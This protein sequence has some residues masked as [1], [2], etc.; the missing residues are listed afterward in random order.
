MSTRQQDPPRPAPPA[1]LEIVE[2]TVPASLDAP[3]SWPVHATVAVSQAVELDV[4]GNVDNALD[5]E[6]VIAGLAE[7]THRRIRRWVATLDGEPVGRGFALLPLTSNTHRASVQVSVV[8]SARRRGVGEALWRTVERVTREEG[9]T[10]L[11]GDSPH[12]PEPP[13]GPGAL[14]PTTGAGRAPADDAGVRFALRHGFTLEQVARHSVLDLPV[15]PEELAALVAEAT[16]AA[17]P[18]YRVHVWTDE[19]PDERLDGIAVLE[20][21]MSTDAPVGGLD[22]REDPW[23]ADRVRAAF[24]QIHEREARYAVCA[25]E[26]V[27]G[28]TLAG[29]TVVTLPEKRPTVV[30]QE[31]TLVLRE[32]RGHRLGMLAKATMLGELGRSFPAAERVHTWN[33]QENDAMLAIN[34]A[35][36]FRPAGIDAEWQRVG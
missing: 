6:G 35:L 19:I 25:V 29:F 11:S 28:G 26:H 23:D 30:F 10:V 18:D 17:G 21:R 7:S 9:R 36:G 15:D 3:D 14:E 33:A 24:A 22:R 20:T 8:P 2:V 12:T 13:P 34:V 1:G 31:D 4:H 16:A 32:H 27:P 5:A